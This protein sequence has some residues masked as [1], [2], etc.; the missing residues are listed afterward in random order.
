MAREVFSNADGFNTSELALYDAIANYEK[1]CP[2]E[3]G[4][5]LQVWKKAKDI[6]DR[7]LTVE[8][9]E[10]YVDLPDD[11]TKEARERVAFDVDGEVDRS[12]FLVAKQLVHERL[13]SKLDEFKMS[14]EFAALLKRMR[15][16]DDVGNT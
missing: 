1:G 7:Y 8:N 12:T 14:A 11:A 16:Y 10:Y 3:G 9:E 4:I 2:G 13:T 5:S 6:V 15:C